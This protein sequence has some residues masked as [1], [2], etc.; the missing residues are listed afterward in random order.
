[1]IK[2]IS[3]TPVESVLCSKEDELEKVHMC[4]VHL[5]FHTNPEGVILDY[6]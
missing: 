1:M 4:Q 6:V 5:H 3:P 2:L